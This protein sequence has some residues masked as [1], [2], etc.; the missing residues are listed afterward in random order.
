MLY[1]VITYLFSQA[2]GDPKFMD[3]IWFHGI[4][5]EMLPSMVIHTIHFN[6]LCGQYHNRMPLLIHPNDIDYWL[7][8]ASDQV[9]LRITSYNVCYTKLLRKICRLPNN[10]I[11]P[12]R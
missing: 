3:G 9:A 5:G 4:D 2:G 8:A 11:K 1:E 7:H 12:R 6:P 10:A